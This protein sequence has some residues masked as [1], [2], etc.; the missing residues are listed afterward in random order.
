MSFFVSWS[1]SQ[2]N[3][4]PISFWK[5]ESW[6]TIFQEQRGKRAEVSASSTHVSYPVFP[7]LCSRVAGVLQT[8]DPPPPTPTPSFPL[9]ENKPPVFCCGGAVSWETLPLKQ[10]SNQFSL[11]YSSFSSKGNWFHQLLS[12]RGIL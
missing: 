8:R 9:P 2:N 12:L 1:D 5:G 11:F 6:A 10:Y 7:S 4:F 3:S